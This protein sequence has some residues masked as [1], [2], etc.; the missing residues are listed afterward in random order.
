MLVWLVSQAGSNYLG[1][2]EIRWAHLCAVI[3]VEADFESR[4]PTPPTLL[5]ARRWAPALPELVLRESNV[6]N[7]M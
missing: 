7:D 5:C 3:C 2:T 4:T 6:E 1:T